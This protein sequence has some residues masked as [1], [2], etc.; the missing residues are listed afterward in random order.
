MALIRSIVIGRSMA[1]QELEDCG[2]TG[3][4]TPWLVFAFTVHD[5]HFYNY[6]KAS[7]RPSKEEFFMAHELP[8]RACVGVDPCYLSDAL[9]CGAAAWYTMVRWTNGPRRIRTDWVHEFIIRDI[10]GTFTENPGKEYFVLPN[11][12]A[13]DQAH[14]SIPWKNGAYTLGPQMAICPRGNDVFKPHRFAFNAA[15]PIFLPGRTAILESEH[16]KAFGIFAKCRPRPN[17]WMMLLAQNQLHNMYWSDYEAFTNMSFV[18]CVHDI[19]KEDYFYLQHSFYKLFDYTGLNGQLPTLPDFSNKSHNN[20][21]WHVTPEDEYLL[22]GKQYD[23]TYMFKDPEPEKVVYSDSRGVYPKVYQVDGNG[24]GTYG[25]DNHFQFKVYK[26]F[27]PNC[28]KPRV[29][30]RNSSLIL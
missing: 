14:C 4:E 15:S 29:A 27:W 25:F 1:D 19:E 16:G 10:D 26:C 13:Y 5:I 23:L 21:D 12:G 24:D 22:N 9:D 17:G 8:A 28:V 2:D 20:F 6:D 30:N 3:I 18:G 7:P 11:T